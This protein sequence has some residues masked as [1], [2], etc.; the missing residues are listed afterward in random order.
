MTGSETTKRPVTTHSDTTVIPEIHSNVRNMPSA[1]T[2]QWSKQ[3]HQGAETEVRSETTS[4][5][6][7]A[8]PDIHARFTDGG[9]VSKHMLKREVYTRKVKIK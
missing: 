4:S 3:S 8:I 2:P 7:T 9:E 6:V 5:D 1:E